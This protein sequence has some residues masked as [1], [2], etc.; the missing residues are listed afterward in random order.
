MDD[1][2]LRY[3]LS[4]EM[5]ARPF[6]AVSVPTTAAFLAIKKLGGAAGR[7]RAKDMAHL[8]ALL[9]RYGVPHPQPGATHYVGKIGRH[10]LKWES[11]TEIVT[12][13]AFCEGLSRAISSYL[14]APE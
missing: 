8:C 7:D 3:E 13:T 2:P 12:Y 4:N 5:H 1:H 6:M 9:D 11:H 14:T 10:W